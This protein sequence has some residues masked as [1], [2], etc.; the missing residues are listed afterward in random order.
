MVILG[1]WNRHGDAMNPVL[2]M[3]HS[4]V[5]LKCPWYFF[6]DVCTYVKN[7]SCENQTT[8]SDVVVYSDISF[9]CG[10]RLNVFEFHFYVSPLNTHLLIL[11]FFRYLI[12]QPFWGDLLCRMDHVMSMDL[13]CQWRHMTVKVYYL[14]HNTF[15]K[16]RQIIHNHKYKFH[17]M[18]HPS[19]DA[20]H[21]LLRQAWC[22]YGQ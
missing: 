3:M 14:Q 17:V 2:L 1:S 22:I 6:N 7:S 4:K 11:M 18:K 19:C 13:C 21:S 12:I 16:W 10:N 9:F 5:C 15:K 8:S 20:L